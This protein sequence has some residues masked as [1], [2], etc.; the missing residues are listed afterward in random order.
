RIVVPLAVFA[1]CHF[2]LNTGL[3]AGAAT[4]GR[5]TSLYRAWRQHFLPLW[6]TY[7]GGASIAGLILL[8]MA[9]GLANLATLTL[10]LPLMVVLLVAV[11]AG[12]QRL[13][14]RSAQFARLRS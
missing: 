2:L 4:I 14:E 9:A 5:Q 7:F 3:V 13:R 11:V 1:A 6:L 10:A 8:L 12:V